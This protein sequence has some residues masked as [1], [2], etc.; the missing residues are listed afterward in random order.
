[1]RGDELLR[2]IAVLLRPRLREATRWRGWAA[3][4]SACCSS[5]AR[6]RRAAHRADAAH[7]VAEFR[8]V[9]KD[10][11]SMSASASAS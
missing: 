9:W 1:M 4:S 10:A 2:Q 11:R 5:T 6:R 3:T 8:F 7:G